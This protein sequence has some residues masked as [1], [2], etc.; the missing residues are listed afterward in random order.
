MNLTALKD[1]Y[2]AVLI[3]KQKVEYY[4]KDKYKLIKYKNGLKE[5]EY[6]YRNGLPHGKN[7]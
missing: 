5:W 1:I 7:I 4:G 2:I 6:I 3:L